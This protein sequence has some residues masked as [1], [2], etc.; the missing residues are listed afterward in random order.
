M[1]YVHGHAGTPEYKAWNAMLCRCLHPNDVS[2]A[3]YG[4]R[5][6]TVHEPWLDFLTFLAD[7]GKRPSAAHTLERIDNDG[8]Y[9]PENCRWALRTEQQRNTR[10]SRRLTRRGRTLTVVEWAAELGMKPTTIYN[11]LAR[12]SSDE[13]AL[14]PVPEGVSR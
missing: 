12:G 8:S 3:N 4:G 13:D 5:G 1:R 11:R 9:S 2:F 7:L 14:A 10:R 6:I